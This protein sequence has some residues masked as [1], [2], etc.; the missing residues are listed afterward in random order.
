MEIDSDVQRDEVSGLI[1]ELMEGEKGKAM[2]KRAEEW[3]DKAVMAAEPDGT[4]H[5]N[6]DQLVRDVLLAKH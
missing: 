1:T 4:S 6:F 3:R 2:R 5:R